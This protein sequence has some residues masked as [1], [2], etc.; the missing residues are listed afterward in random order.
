MIVEQ[1]CEGE[2]LVLRVHAN[3]R[4]PNPLLMVGRLA[5]LE[6]RIMEI[7][8]L[9]R[10]RLDVGRPHILEAV[11]AAAALEAANLYADL[12]TLQLGAQAALERPAESA[13]G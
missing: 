2:E 9:E 10:S 11:T 8:Q 7:L 1:W 3:V 6:R 13:G 4:P 5:E 12:R